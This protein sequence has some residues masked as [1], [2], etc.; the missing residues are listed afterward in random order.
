MFQPPDLMRFRRQFIDIHCHRATDGEHLHILSLDTHELDS[1][2]GGPALPPNCY[3]SLGIHPWYIARQDEQSALQKLQS[4]LGHSRLLAI[5]ECGLDK[6]VATDMAKQIRLFERQAAL[7]EGAR[8]PLMIHCVRAYH[9]L[10]RIKKQRRSALPWIVH[11]YNSKPQLAEQLLDQGCYLSL[12]KAL[13]QQESNAAQTLTRLPVD[14]LFLETDAATDI[15]IDAIY[16]AA[17]KITGLSADALRRQI[18]LN[19]GRVFFHD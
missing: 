13:L 15:S 8:K 6:T 11:G 4:Y 3:F 5:G 12:G 17:A 14:R 19:F 2:A 7:A 1:A 9:E 10:L 16:A 18:F